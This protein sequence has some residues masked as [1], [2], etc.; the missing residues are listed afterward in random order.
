[1]NHNSKL[2]A[3]R[4]L[5]SKELTSS[6]C[7]VSGKKWLSGINK[8]SREEIKRD[9]TKKREQEKTSKSKLVGVSESRRIRWE[10]KTGMGC[11]E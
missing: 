5:R 9:L 2:R 4:K 1:V 11:L 8:T 7:Y 10:T 3:E 6:C